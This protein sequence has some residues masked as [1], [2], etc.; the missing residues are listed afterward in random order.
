M[1]PKPETSFL[2]VIP[3]EESIKRD[4]Q[5]HDLTVDSLQL[6]KEKI[7]LYV[8]LKEAGKWSHIMDGMRT[9]EELHKQVKEILK[10]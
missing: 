3:P 2:F 7:D 1:S 8:K 4:I 5:K 10:I 9:I 6:K